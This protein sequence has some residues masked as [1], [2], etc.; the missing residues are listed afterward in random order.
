MAKFKSGD[1]W[2]GN[3]KGRPISIERLELREALDKAKKEHNK[4]F[5]EHFVSRA[6]EDNQCA[7]ALAKK[8]LPDK[9]ENEHIGNALI[10]ELADGIIKKRE[11]DGNQKKA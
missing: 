6:Y 5:L 8:L 4:T 10:L 11:E 9:I 7:I 3:A 1:E 2:T